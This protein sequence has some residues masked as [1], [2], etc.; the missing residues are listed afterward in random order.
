MQVGE[1]GGFG[2]EVNN[3]PAENE[4]RTQRHGNLLAGGKSPSQTSAAVTHGAGGEGNAKRHHAGDRGAGNLTTGSA[5]LGKVPS[6]AMAIRLPRCH[7]GFPP[8][9]AGR[10]WCPAST[11]YSDSIP[12]G[13]GVPVRQRLRT[14]AECRESAESPATRTCCSHPGQGGDFG[15]ASR[16]ID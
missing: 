3:H 4:Q 13:N 16:C 8:A 6:L 7:L 5:V 14:R 1:R 12:I 10:V 15:R 2:A 11:W 9:P